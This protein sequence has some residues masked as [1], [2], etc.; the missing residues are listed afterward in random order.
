MDAKQFLAEFGHIANA[1]GGVVRLRE[2]ILRL[3]TQGKLVSQ[4]FSDEHSLDLYKRIQA[5]KSRL[6]AIGVP[7]EKNHC[8]SLSKA[9][10]HMN[11]HRIGVGND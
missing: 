2:L 1:P 5:E 3:A 9:I 10:Y 8:L 4:D 11:C 7:K 6:I